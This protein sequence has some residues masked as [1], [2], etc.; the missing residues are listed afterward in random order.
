M[1]KI[2]LSYMTWLEVKE[3]IKQRPTILIPIGS[4][5]AQNLHNPTGYDY[6]IA[7][8][9]AESVAQKCN[10]VMLPTIPF[11]YSHVFADFPGTILLRPETLRF[12]FEDI[13]KSLNR[14][15]FDHLL[16][17]NNH[18]PNHQPLTEVIYK[19]KEKYKILYTSIF[20][21]RLAKSFF[22]DLFP[23]AK[24]VL[25]HGNEPS[26]S[27]IRYLYPELQR[28]DLFKTTKRPSHYKNFKLNPISS[29]EYQGEEI[30]AFLNMSDISKEGGW[31]NS[32]GD[33][34]IGK[35]IFNKMVNF[36][37]SFVCEFN[38]TNI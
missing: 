36:I 7:E 23:N 27:L 19:L 6:L 2:N 18:Q 15:G 22:Q 38:K 26:T 16:F 32:K 34:E 33:V 12:I 4:T 3:I 31:S 9:L 21:S 37:V 30:Y 1:K 14:S 11:G 29:F 10:A 25:N 20:P 13:I 24:K 17:L 28:L 8:R 35:T 5:E